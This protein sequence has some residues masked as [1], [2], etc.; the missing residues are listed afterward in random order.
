MDGEELVHHYGVPSTE[1]SGV[2]QARFRPCPRDVGE[3][4]RPMEW[5]GELTGRATAFTGMGSF[6]ME[7]A[8]NSCW[9]KPVNAYKDRKD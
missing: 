4:F 8:A 5:K 3:L 6:E 2:P 9:T 1:D 7:T